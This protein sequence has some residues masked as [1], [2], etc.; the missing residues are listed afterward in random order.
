[1]KH[2]RRTRLSAT[3]LVAISCAPVGARPRADA[4]KAASK[5]TA[6]RALAANGGARAAT[7]PEEPALAAPLA[8]TAPV[9]PEPL[10][11]GNPDAIVDLKTD[12]GASLVAATWRYADVR[13]VEKT[14]LGPGPDLKASGKNVLAYDYEPKAFAPSFDDSKWANVR[15]SDLEARRGNG[16]LSFAW[17]RLNLTLPERVGDVDV[18][19][20]AVAFEIVVDDYAEVW[21]DGKLAPELGQPGGSVVGGFNV[22]NRVLLTENA[23]PGR[24]FSVAVFAMNGPISASP[25]NFIWVRSASLELHRP[26][27]REKTAG[28]FALFSDPNANRI[29]RYDPR[30]GGALSIFRTHSGYTGVDVGTFHQPGSN[31]LAIDPR[32]RVTLCEHGNR[33]VTR[34]EPNGSLTVLA[35]RYQGHRLNSPNDLVYRSDGALYF[36]DPPFGLPSTFDDPKKEL[37]Y[38]GIFRFKGGELTL[39][40]RSLNGPNGLGFSPDEK[41][42]YVTNWD[43]ARKIIERWDVAP[44]GSISNG[45]VFFDMGSAPEEEAL[46]GLEVDA[47]GNVYASG[48]G[49]VWILSPEG[50]HL[51]TLEVAELPANLEWGDPDGK[52]L[53]M[54]SR[55]S[56]YRIRLGIPGS[57]FERNRRA[58]G[59]GPG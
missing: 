6:L 47:E 20:S 31:G 11:R 58:A 2:F 36:S 8:I 34:L 43:A 55:T 52:S 53:Y 15:A 39:L 29:Y 51:G 5:V 7:T 32:G 10:P 33:R 19:G 48:P 23:E 40:D 17:Y 37:P 9:A 56:L 49:G 25:S 13:I 14:S 21:V 57:R 41:T 30:A 50:R 28:P 38:S 1:M 46:D 22:P 42:F 59:G 16:H 54:T 18:R 4:P 45:R 44:D 26:E 3:L 24:T 27:R 35:D 12:D